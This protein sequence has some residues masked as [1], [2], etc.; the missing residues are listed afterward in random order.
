MKIEGSVGEART[1]RRMVG[2]TAS[3]KNNMKYPI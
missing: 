2:F 3:E 1:G